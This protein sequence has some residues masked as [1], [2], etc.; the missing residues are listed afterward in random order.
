VEEQRAEVE[1][2]RVSV[3]QERVR[4]IAE[5]EE[6]RAE[7]LAEVASERAALQREIKAVHTHTDAQ[8][9]RVVLNVGDHKFETSVQTLRRLSGP[10]APSLTPTSS[11]GHYAV[12]DRDGEHFGHVL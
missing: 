2:E 12:M 3:E 10:R 4:G 7:V 5:V 1:Q 6:R 11:S 8:T 9:G